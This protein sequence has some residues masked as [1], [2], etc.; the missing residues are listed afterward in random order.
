MRS[1]YLSDTCKFCKRLE[2]SVLGVVSVFCYVSIMPQLIQDF[3]YKTCVLGIWL[4]SKLQDISRSIF[5][6]TGSPAQLAGELR[7]Q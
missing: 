1:P 7:E 6:S 5:K 3:S 4:L 2:L